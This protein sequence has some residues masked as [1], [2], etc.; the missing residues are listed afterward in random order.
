MFKFKLLFIALLIQIALSGCGQA[1]QIRQSLPS[2]KPLP[3]LQQ[4]P[5]LTGTWTVGM[6]LSGGFA[7]LSQSIEI[8]SDGAVVAKDER[9]GKTVKRQLT[10][11]ELAQFTAL[12]KLVS[13]KSSNGD[14]TGC[15]DCFIYNIQI[16]SSSGKS[17]AQFDDVSLP[18]SGMSSVVQ[19]LRDL[20]SQMLTSG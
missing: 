6:Q 2:P 15:A 19:Y 5:E 9:N 8:S 20:M 16:N 4:I 17:T 7:G 13:L 1:T 14:P 11:D 12:I 10:S 3:A 18:D